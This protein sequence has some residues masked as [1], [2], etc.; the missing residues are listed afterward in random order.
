MVDECL[1]YD[2]E[3]PKNGHFAEGHAL[4]PPQAAATLRWQ[5]GKVSVT[6]GP[7]AEIKEQL[8]GI[9]IPAAS[10]RSPCTG[11]MAPTIQTKVSSPKLKRPAAS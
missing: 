9:L 6:D 11:R 3:L 2:D 5:D 1:A 8:G 4:Q 10:R 7:N